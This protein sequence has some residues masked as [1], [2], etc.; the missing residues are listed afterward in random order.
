MNFGCNNNYVFVNMSHEIFMNSLGNLG[1]A[2][3]FLLFKP[4]FD[5]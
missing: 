2:Y 1:K 5:A 3:Q 4:D